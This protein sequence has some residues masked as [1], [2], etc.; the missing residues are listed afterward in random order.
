MKGNLRALFRLLHLT[1]GLGVG[2]WFIL[3]GSTGAI[4]VF[5]P[6]V[7]AALNPSLLRAS[8]PVKGKPIGLQEA[9]EIARAA[10]PEV[11]F[12]RLLPPR[13]PDGVYSFRWQTPQG[14]Q[15][16]FVDPA[17][18]RITGARNRTQTVLWKALELHKDLLLHETGHRIN[19]V[20]ALAGTALLLSGVILWLP[21]SA[22]LLSKRLTI[23]RN[24]SPGR[25]LF[26]LHNVLGIYSLPV[27]LLVTVTGV[28][29]LY[30]HQTEQLAAMVWKTEGNKH[31]DEPSATVAKNTIPA[32]H[33]AQ[34]SLDTLVSQHR[35]VLGTGG[36]F[37][38]V[39]LPADGGREVILYG[40]P[41]GGRRWGDRIK[42]TVD[43]VTGEIRRLEDNRTAPMKEKV[44]RWLGPLH[45]GRWGDTAS[46]ALYVLVG[47]VVPL[48]LFVTGAL[49]WWQRRRRASRSA[50][51]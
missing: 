32:G 14:E 20:L 28:A 1:L 38:S 48:G 16:L 45:F 42:V 4:M 12:K 34:H 24:T 49:R 46:K 22:K 37:T 3:L 35:E 21:P 7:D 18:G 29:F 25:F 41:A 11:S 19:G 5:W 33:E 10:R 44:V 39:E 2:L 47:A 51:R 15:E 8:G 9:W 36:R 23:Q 43:T 6:E 50:V 30:E 27:M 13:T 31:G 26:D 40:E 17:T